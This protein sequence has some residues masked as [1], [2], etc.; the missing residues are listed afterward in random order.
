MHH[1]SLVQSFIPPHTGVKHV[2]TM[3]Y[4]NDEEKKELL[5]LNEKEY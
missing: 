2:L 4:L 5:D 3:W 1:I